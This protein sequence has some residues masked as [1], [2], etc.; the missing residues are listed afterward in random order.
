MSERKLVYIASPYAGNR[1]ANVRFAKAACR[2]AIEQGETPV[3]VHLMYPQI[4]SDDIP[5]ERDL[6]MH[7]GL[8]VLET[9]DELWLCGNHISAGMRAEL[10]QAEKL[11][12]PVR[13]VT[14][15][16]I[17]QAQSRNGFEKAAVQE[18][19]DVPQPRMELCGC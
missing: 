1:E 7:M 15:E 18:K 11:G 17:E 4:L 10:C 6:G 8:R 14:A 13:M 9:C 16:E 19:T 3:A 12:I 2:Y 5:A